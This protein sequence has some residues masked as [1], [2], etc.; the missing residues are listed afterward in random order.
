MKLTAHDV[1]KF[2]KDNGV[3]MVDLKFMDFPGIWQHTGKPVSEIDEQIFE[4][5]QGFDGSSIRGWQPIHASDML[6]MP[7]PTTMVLDP[8]Y[9]RKTVS[10]VC[11][12]LD[13]ITR[14]GYSR[15]PRYIAQ[16]AE[17]Y[18]KASGIG[19]TSFMGPEAEFF[20]FDDVRYN[21]AQGHSFYYVD[22]VEA[23]WNTGRDEKPNL[24]FKPR[25]KEGY[26]PVPPT[27][28]TADLRAEMC[29]VM[30]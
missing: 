23:Q 29:R 24:G 6:L 3:E 16:K 15:D 14:E 9:E 25:Y 22:S 30:E 12:I 28:A 2:I 5:G 21:T 1:V 19:D 27:D 7:D 11:N 8:F 17:A 20:I 13:P 4:E 18:L 26:F 10:L